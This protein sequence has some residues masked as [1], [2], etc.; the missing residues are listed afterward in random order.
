MGCL[1]STR[2]AVASIPAVESWIIFLAA[3]AN[4]VGTALKPWFASSVAADPATEIFSF[5]L[6]LTRLRT[7]A[8]SK[9]R[10]ARTSKSTRRVPQEE[11]LGAVASEPVLNE[12]EKVAAERFKEML[13][14]LTAGELELFALGLLVNVFEKD[15]AVFSRGE[16]VQLQQFVGASEVFLLLFG[17]HT[18]ELGFANAI[19]LSILAIWVLV[20]I[21]VFIFDGALAL[22]VVLV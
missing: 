9:G 19:L 14:L 18:K 8:S 20:A 4:E 17:E 15:V 22:G 5:F 7:E 21:V 6:L 2:K 12:G 1:A 16:L 3:R 11:S 13:L 10:P